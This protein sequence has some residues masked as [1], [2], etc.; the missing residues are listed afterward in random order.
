M[1]PHPTPPELNDRGPG[2]AASVVGNARRLL[3]LCL[4]SLAVM[5]PWPVLGILLTRSSFDEPSEAF[6]LLGGVTMFP[7]MLLAL[8]GTVPKVVLIALLM[9]VW[10]AAAVVPGLWLRRRLTSRRGVIGLLGVQTAFSLA[11]AAMGALLVLGK[12][13]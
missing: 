8:F 10:L 4:G 7:L 3:S 5:T 9:L 11:Q 2:P 12:N 6:L 13:V 1:T